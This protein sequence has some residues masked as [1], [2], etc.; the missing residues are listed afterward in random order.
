M[1]IWAP[2]LMSQVSL[3]LGWTDAADLRGVDNPKAVARR[4]V[5][6]ALLMSGAMSSE[7]ESM[8]GKGHE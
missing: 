5:R 4:E 1:S 2:L 6:A 7:I 3:W 8:E